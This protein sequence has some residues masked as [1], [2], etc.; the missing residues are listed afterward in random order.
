MS[1]SSCSQKN[2]SKCPKVLVLKPVR[3]SGE[4]L[5]PKLNQLRRLF[6]ITLISKIVTKEEAKDQIRYL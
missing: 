5:S 3:V 4:T 2:I 6:L 1:Q